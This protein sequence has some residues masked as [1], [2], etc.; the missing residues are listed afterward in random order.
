MHNIWIQFSL[1]GIFCFRVDAFHGFF[2][3]N[4]GIFSGVILLDFCD[5]MLRSSSIALTFLSKEHHV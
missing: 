5:M 3:Y 1:A 2:C 4:S